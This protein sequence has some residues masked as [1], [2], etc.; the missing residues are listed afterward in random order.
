VFF[1]ERREVGE[2]RIGGIDGCVESIIRGIGDPIFGEYYK[3]CFAK[4]VLGLFFQ[5]FFDVGGTLCLMCYSDECK[6]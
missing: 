1:G 5:D 4:F 3:I 2:V 6:F